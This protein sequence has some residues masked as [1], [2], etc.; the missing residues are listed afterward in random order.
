MVVQDMQY[1]HDD[2]G[3]GDRVPAFHLVTVDGG[4]FQSA[5]LGPLPVLMVFGSR[6]CPITESAAPQL[7]ALHD[8]YRN[9]IRFVM[10]NTREAHPGELITQ[11]RT[12]ADKMEHARDLERH[13]DLPFEVAVD[14]LDGTLH[15]AFS[16]KPNSA[17]L[18]DPN[19]TILFRAHWANDRRSLEPA[20]HAAAEGRIPKRGRSRA[21]VRPLMKAVGHLPAV[22]HDAGPKSGRDVW[23]AALPLAVLARLSRPFRSLP[24]DTRGW[25]AAALLGLLFVVVVLASVTAVS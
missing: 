13:H 21:M 5:A 1:R 23:R 9:R 19:G 25:A 8:R 7:K 11:P 14:D 6:T 3:P 20:L 24:I 4:G 18:I 17:Y 12:S 16:P 15:R 2:L 10:V 22:V